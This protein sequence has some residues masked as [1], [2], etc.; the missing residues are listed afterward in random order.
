MKIALVGCGAIAREHLKAMTRFSDLELVALSDIS[1]E[2]AA[3][4]CREWKIPHYY[5]ELSKML[6]EQEV[7]LLTIATPPDTHAALAVEAVKRGVNVLI[8]KPLTSTTSDAEEI[9]TALDENPVKLTVNYNWLM[10]RSMIEALSIVGNGG[11]GE[12][13][14]VDMKLLHTREDAMIS[15]EDHW[16]HRLPGGRLGEMLSHPVYVAQSVL[17]HK[18]NVSM[19]LAEKRGSYS[20]VHTD[21]LRLSLQNGKS[22]AYAYISFNAPRPALMVDIYGTLRILRI[23]LLNQT[24]LKLGHRGLGRVDSAADCIGASMNLLSQVALNSLRYLRSGAGEDPLR[25]IYS[26]FVRSIRRDEKP[27]VTV[28]MAYNTVKIAAELCDRLDARVRQ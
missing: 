25:R 12:V 18:L 19:V 27:M 5:T 4:M 6:D 13:L 2:A 9:L 22:T 8:E 21:E 7:S 11:I 14:G 1:E 23:D 10:G 16:S 15:N 24:L 20:W 28:D 26:S 17:G 3:R